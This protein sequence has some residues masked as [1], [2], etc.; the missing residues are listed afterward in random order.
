MTTVDFYNGRKS[1]TPKSG[2]NYILKYRHNVT[3]FECG[4]L[5][6]GR[7]FMCANIAQTDGTMI[8]KVHMEWDTPRIM[9][10]WMDRRA[11]NGVPVYWRNNGPFHIH[12]VAMADADELPTRMGVKVI[13]TKSGQ[14]IVGHVIAVNPGY[15][16]FVI[17][18][19]SGS[20]WQVLRTYVR[21]FS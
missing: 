5:H 15:A 17:A 21:H 8:C 20:T 12:S 18:D 2:Q 3:G 14:D 1:I 19:E 4:P 7:A 16:T 13:G 6:G 10:A 9:L 11:W